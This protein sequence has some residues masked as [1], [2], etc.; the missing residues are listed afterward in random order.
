HIRGTIAIHI[1]EH[2]PA[3]QARGD[4][5]LEAI[6]VSILE[7]LA[8]DRNVLEIAEGL[9]GDVLAALLARATYDHVVISHRPRPARWHGF[10]HPVGAGFQIG[11]AVVAASI[12]ETVVFS[13]IKSAVAVAIE[14]DRPAGQAGIAAV[15]DAIAIGILKDLA[16][17][18][19]V[20]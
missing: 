13:R 3:G 6:A 14:E 4:L 2:G 5:V 19:D 18:R 7:E 9:P 15:R 8:A 17:D 1:Q 12:R 20:L 16:A 10:A 11:E